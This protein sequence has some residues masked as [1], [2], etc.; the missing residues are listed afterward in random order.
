MELELING[1]LTATV[2]KL[3]M[4]PAKHLTYFKSNEENYR[5]DIPKSNHFK[6]INNI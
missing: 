3:F 6:I 4:N 5:S 2:S 1:I